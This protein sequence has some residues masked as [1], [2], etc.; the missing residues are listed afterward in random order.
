MGSYSKETN[1]AK[2][3]GGGEGPGR[4]ITKNCLVAPR[5]GRF[6]RQVRSA[7]PEERFKMK[8]AWAEGFGD[9]KFRQL[10]MALHCGSVTI[11]SEPDKGTVVTLRLPRP[12][13][14]APTV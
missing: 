11:L 13:P 6:T 10:Q 1:F 8:A 2:Q 7:A 4:K 9:P 3:E 12:E 14:A 5:S